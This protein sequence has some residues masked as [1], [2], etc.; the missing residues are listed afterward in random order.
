MIKYIGDKK[1]C[2]KCKE[3]KD[4]NLFNTWKNYADGYYPSCKSCK[5]NAKKEWVRNN[6]DKYLKSKSVYSKDYYIKNRES[7][8]KKTSEYIKKNPHI[9]R[10]SLLNYYYGLSLEA[11]QMLVDKNNG[12]CYIC[13]EFPIKGKLYV[14]HCH[15][16]Q[17]I[18]GV[19]CIKC[20]SLLGFCNDNIEVLNSAIK[21]LI[22]E[23]SNGLE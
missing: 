10:K 3:A 8:I 20:N 16:T 13:N 14:D 11:Y 5:D 17:K 1:I 9:R 2:S 21:Y 15:V 12:K 19:L 23:Q 22:K 7:I 6:R 18:R 4:T